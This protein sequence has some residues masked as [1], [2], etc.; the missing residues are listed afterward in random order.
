MCIV[1]YLYYSFIC[2]VHGYCIFLNRFLLSL[3][4]SFFLLL[5]PYF[6]P[7]FFLLSQKK[8]LRNNRTVQMEG[9]KTLW[10]QIPR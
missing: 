9:E 5:N 1:F 3:S 10:S 8:I 4:L 6:I 2:K 7:S